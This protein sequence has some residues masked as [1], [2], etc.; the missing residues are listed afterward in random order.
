MT[1]DAYTAEMSSVKVTSEGYA[2]HHRF[3]PNSIINCLIM[4][5]NTYFRLFNYMRRTQIRFVAQSQ[6]MSDILRTYLLA[7]SETCFWG[8]SNRLH[9][10]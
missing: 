10:I 6:S 8:F 1:S 5:F 3:R 9:Y 7:W 4:A 2:A